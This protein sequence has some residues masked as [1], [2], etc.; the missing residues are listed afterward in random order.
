MSSYF[1]I[2]E[3]YE[4]RSAS[5]I[6]NYIKIAV[7]NIKKQKIY[8]LITL[9]GLILGLCF[10]IMFALLTDFISNFDLFHKNADRIYAVVQVLPGGSAGEQHS[11]ITPAPLLPALMNEFPKIFPAR[12]NDRQTRGQGLL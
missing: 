7:R 9:S 3:G 6:K 5:M 8:S 2:W 1:L 10:F 11:A 4:F 12:Q